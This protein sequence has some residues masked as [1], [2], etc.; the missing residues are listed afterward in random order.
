[1]FTARPALR[2]G[3]LAVLT[4][5]TLPAC[6]LLFGD[7]KYYCGGGH[8]YR[9]VEGVELRAYQEPVGGNAAA[10]QTGQS[11]VANRLR[12]Y[13]SLQER[14]YGAAPSRGGFVAW[15]DCISP[16]YTEEVDSVTIFSRYAYDARHPAGTSL[17]DIVQVVAT[18][19]SGVPSPG[20]P[21][22][23]LSQVQPPYSA[24]AWTVQAL[25]LTVA[26]AQAGTQQFR[27]RYHQTNGEV[28]EAETPLLTVQL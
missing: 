25:K 6:E 11:V 16:E 15:A 23:L 9:D 7:R 20:T 17:N 2:I 4:G 27:L 8:Q 26:P 22:T 19:N 1:M 24:E 28:Y 14:G 21:V 13:V 10:L 18:V 12:L 3:L 5:L